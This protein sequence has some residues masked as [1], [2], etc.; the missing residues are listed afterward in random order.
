MPNAPLAAQPLHESDAPG[1]EGP[2]PEEL[3]ADTRPPNRPIGWPFNSC[4]MP[5]HKLA[6]ACSE[7]T[8]LNLINAGLQERLNGLMN[9]KNE[10]VKRCKVLQRQ[11][12]QARRGQP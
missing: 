10:A 3:A 7:I 9:E 8:R 2:S 11:L 12:D 5:T 4:W 6:T 1:D